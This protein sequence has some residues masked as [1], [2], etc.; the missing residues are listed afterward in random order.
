RLTITRDDIRHKTLQPGLVLTRQYQA[1]PYVGMLGQS[2]F[3]FCRFD[4]ET[5]QF[6]LV[7]Y[8]AQIFNIPGRQPAAQIASLIHARRSCTER[9][10][11]ETLGGE[12][13][14]AEIASGQTSSREIEFTGHADRQ[15]VEVLVQNVAFFLRDRLSDRD[16]RTAGYQCPS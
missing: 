8:T 4:A 10:A 11:N 3:Y 14:T 16:W 9:V 2:R 15:R 12:I 13:R 1:L 6:D 7:I 5:A